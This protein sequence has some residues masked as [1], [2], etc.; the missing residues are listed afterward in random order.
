MDCKL[1]IVF[2][3]EEILVVNKPSGLPSVP[4]KD[5]ALQDCIVS[6]ARA[7]CPTMPEYCAAHR[8]DMDTSG[9]MILAKNGTTLRHLFRQFSERNVYKE[10]EA[11]IQGAPLAL[12]QG[13]IELP[14]RL[15]VDNRPYQIFDPVHGKLGITEW[16]LIGEAAPGIWRM[17][18]IPFTGRTHQ[19][20][21]HMAHKFGL[22]RP[23][24]GD[25]LYGDGKGPG[26]LKLHATVLRLTHPVSGEML[27]FFS[28]PSF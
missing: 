7:Y 27:D 3:D 22:G 8:L 23:I 28:S 16:Q 2:E 15:D 11:L 18:L 26:E 9:L 10:Y 4:G 12:R 25:R 19:L 21:L 1:C 5:E 14:F 24:V 13:R 20:R 17:R 6:R